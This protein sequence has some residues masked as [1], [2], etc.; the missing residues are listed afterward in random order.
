[1]VEL[2]VYSTDTFF[3]IENQTNIVCLMQN[4]HHHHLTKILLV[5]A[6][7]E[8]VHLALNNNPES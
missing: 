8:N 4:R 1:M 3:Y 2:H 5:L 6:M 7:K